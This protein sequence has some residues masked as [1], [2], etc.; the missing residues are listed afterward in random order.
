MMIKFFYGLS[1]FNALFCSQG[2][3]CNSNNPTTQMLLAI[4]TSFSAACFEKCFDQLLFLNYSL[5]ILLLNQELSLSLE[6]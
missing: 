3:Y 6:A 1:P 2:Q 4:E 5:L